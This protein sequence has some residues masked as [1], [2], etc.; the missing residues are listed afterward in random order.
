MTC[1]CGFH[2]VAAQKI[3]NVKHTINEKDIKVFPF[4]KSL[5]TALYGKEKPQMKLPNAFTLSIDYAIL[6]YLNRNEEAVESIRRDLKDHY[7]I[8]NL[9]QSSVHLSPMATLGQQKDA[10]VI[11][12]QWRKRVEATC[13]Q[14]LSKFR[15]LKFSEGSEAWEEIEETIRQMLLKE[16]VVTVP[17]KAKGVISVAGP[18]DVVDQVEK[19]INE[20]IIK[21]RKQLQRKNSSKTETINLLPAVFSILIQSE[22]VTELGS[23]YPELQIIHSKDGPGLIVTGLMEEIAEVRKVILN[24]VMKIKYQKLE[25]DCFV[26]DMLKEEGEQELTNEFLTSYGINAAFKANRNKLEL[27]AVTDEALNDAQDHL[28]KLLI[29]QYVDVEDINVFKM[30]EWDHQVRQTESVNSRLHDRIQIRTTDQQVVVSGHRDVVRS[31]STELENFLK[32]NAHVEEAVVIKP[33]AIL[34]YI[35]NLEKSKMEQL[36][37][38]VA[39][40][41]KNEALCLSGSRANV[42]Q[43][44]TVVENLVSSVLVETLTVSAP[45]A[46]KWFV[47]DDNMAS[48]FNETGCLVELVDETSGGQGDL[49]TKPNYVY[50]L[51]T[52]D[53]TEIAIYKA[54]ICS[55]PVHAVVTYANKNLKLVG[56]LAKALIKAAGPQLQKEC[57]NFIQLKGQLKTGDCAITAS[58][59]QL[60]CRNIIHAV[61]PRLG[62]DQTKCSKRLAQLNKAIKGS[63]ELAE[64]NGCMS[65]ALPAL[66]VTSGFPLKLGT[67]TIA[68]AV[69]EYI[70]EKHEDSMLKRIH[71]VDI[72]DCSVAAIVVAVR[73]HFKGDCATQPSR[74]EVPSVTASAST[75]TH[76]THQSPSDPVFLG[77]AQT[78]E[79][80]NVTLVVGNIEDATVIISFYLKCTIFVSFVRRLKH[81]FFSKRFFRLT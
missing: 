67:D 39:V 10:K 70:D 5:G 45:G 27:A 80:L 55:H 42:L 28:V 46:K 20:R 33:N 17:D 19:N 59:G 56:A 24:Q 32:Q 3:L 68:K 18:V 47:N 58:T 4:H 35:K 2:P 1:V 31:A 63:L 51:Q 16:E 81:P 15:C 41:F 66:S 30:P 60:C 25:M 22:V 73:E 77:Q 75:K 57:D 8:V 74:P 79:G 34:K 52:S 72:S 21:I 69:R 11:I 50:Q 49:T 61:A 40:S 7:C 53:G 14:S 43:C 12:N 37:D 29:S 62:V 54:D 38:K 65:V 64:K 44:K 23:A 13:N 78:K 36:Q 9:D 48:H 26:L 71:F 6:A 76:Q